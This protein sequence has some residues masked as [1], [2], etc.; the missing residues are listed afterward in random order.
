MRL[1]DADGPT[2]VGLFLVLAFALW[3]LFFYTA[4]TPPTTHLNAATTALSATAASAAAASTAPSSSSSSSAAR[5]YSKSAPPVVMV[6]SFL[7]E[8]PHD[9]QA[10]TQGLLVHAGQLWES[11]GLYGQ[12]SLRR[13]DLETGRVADSWILPQQYFGEGLTLVGNRLIQLTWQ[14]HLGLVYDLA[15]ATTQGPRGQ[16]SLPNHPSREGWGIAT[17]PD[18]SSLVMSDGSATL[19]FLDPLSFQVQR[20]V[21]VKVWVTSKR[22]AGAG[23]G[24]GSGSVPAGSLQPVRMLNELEWIGSLLYANI[25]MTTL[26]AVIDPVSGLVVQ[27]IDLRALQPPNSSADMTLNGIAWDKDKGKLFVTGKLWP[28]LFEIELPRVE[29]HKSSAAP[30]RR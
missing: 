3:L 6:S 18:E 7:R 14:N 20:T 11:T 29:E 16:F 8:F 27:W 13:V 12:S 26:I 22:A 2:K 17:S 25:W 21:E 4:P 24:S 19:T 23:S 28:K 5:D 10:F 1:G 15:S 30:A 9:P